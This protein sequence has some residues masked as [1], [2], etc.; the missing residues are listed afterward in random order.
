LISLTDK[1]I[2]RLKDVMFVRYRDNK[3]EALR[4]ERHGY[5]RE[6]AALQKSIGGE[7]TLR[8]PVDGVISGISVSAGGT[9]QQGQII[10]EVVDPTALWVEAS[11]Y[12]LSAIGEIE[13]ATARLPDGTL[14]ELDYAGGGL[15]LANQAVPL[16][17]RIRNAPEGLT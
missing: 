11:A 4:V 7:E 8:A 15:V 9:A 6:L 12:D 14:L 5:R 1:Q 10:V 3:I 13:S 16:R 2:Q 17:F